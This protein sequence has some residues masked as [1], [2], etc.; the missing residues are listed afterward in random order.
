MS[1]EERYDIALVR[2]ESKEQV[3]RRIEELLEQRNDICNCQTCVLDLLAFTLN[4]VTPSY[5][6]SILG[7]LH[8]DTVRE[9]KMQIEIDLALKAG[10][11]RLQQHPHH[12]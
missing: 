9:K 6:T 1:L 5:S 3:C 7:D 12:D 8:P 2:N 4:R 11:K 10:L